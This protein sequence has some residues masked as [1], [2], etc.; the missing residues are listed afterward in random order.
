MEKAVEVQSSFFPAMA[1]LVK[2]T[3]SQPDLEKSFLEQAKKLNDHLESQA[4]KYF[5]GNTLSL[6]DFSLAPK[7]YHMDITLAEFHP[8]VHEKVVKM[9]AL[10]AYMDAM[11][12]EEAFKTS[13]Y[14]KETVLWGWSAARQK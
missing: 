9:K 7:L 6:I 12:A 5:A 3:K 13:T 4:T 1:K 10:K 2:S 8:K 14:P 11:F